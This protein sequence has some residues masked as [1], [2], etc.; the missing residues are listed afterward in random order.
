VGRDVLARV[1]SLTFGSGA[2]VLGDV[3]YR[4]SS[5]AATDDDVAI[6]GQFIRRTV[7]APVWAK[8]LTRVVSILSLLALIVAGLAASWVFRAT[9][10]R[11][12]EM[13]EDQPIRSAVVGLVFIVALP[14][15]MIPLFLTLV[16]IP[17]AL[18][19]LLVWLL[20]LLLGP[21]PAVTR[22]G[23]LLLRG[24]GGTAAALVIGAVIWRGAMWLLPLV[25]GLV[26]L[27]ALVV[28]LGGYV[29]AGWS[30]RRQSA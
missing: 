6:S 30:L 22:F 13:V 27:A 18:L 19:V 11:A 7:L 29:T 26:Y 23:S 16:G 2:R 5:D 25:A 4:A 10:V 28:G 8:A 1:D 12:V 15:L 21:I 3:L 24:N 9:S 17:V 20:A 14:V